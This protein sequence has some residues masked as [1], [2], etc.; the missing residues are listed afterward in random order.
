[1]SGLRRSI[2]GRRAG[3][4]MVELMVATGLSSM[5]LLAL[6]R[7][8]DTAMSMWTKGENRR[9]V[10]EYASATAE[11]MARDVRALHGG[12]QGDLLAE[13]IAYDLDRD[14]TVDRY[15]P[16]LRFIRQASVS[17]IVRTAALA[18][19]PELQAEALRQGVELEL[20]IP[21]EERQPPPLKSGLLQVAW[22]VVPAAIKGESRF[23]GVLMR[24]EGLLEPGTAGSF[25]DDSFF[26]GSGGARTAALH[27]VTGGVLWMGMQF[28]SQTSIIWD[29]WQI[30]SQ[31]EDTGGSWDAWKSDRPDPEVHVWNEPAAGMPAIE[32]RPLLPRR[33]RFEFE[34]QRERDL[35]RRTRTVAAL[36]KNQDAFEVEDGGAVPYQRGRHILIGGEWMEV[37]RVQGERVHVRRGVRGTAPRLHDAGKLVHYGA[38]VTFEVPIALHSD[39][40][41]LGGVR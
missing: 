10:V 36:E 38:P 29:G 16:R 19:D 8:L 27:E 35:Q 17:D 7:L 25:F 9:M 40:W 24:G 1:M 18:V 20:L 37:Q 30:G 3:M 14:G 33:V 4:T 5:L 15:W 23:E 2:A 12:Q 21:E 41:N 11:L 13:W 6:F 22:T 39:N 34:F 32:E 26:S 31:L 28:A